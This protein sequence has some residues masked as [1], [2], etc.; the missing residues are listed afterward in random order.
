MY[1]LE[2]RWGE[3]AVSLSCALPA[4]GTAIAGVSKATKL[5]KAGS[6]IGQTMKYAGKA[7]MSVQIATKALE[8]AGDA[9]VQYAVN[10]GKVTWDVVKE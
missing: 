7:Y 1:A 9:K 4:I 8:L 6:I 5:A 10:G 3:A 2:G